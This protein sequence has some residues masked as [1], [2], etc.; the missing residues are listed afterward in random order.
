M[1]ECV[2]EFEYAGVS[3]ED[4]TPEWGIRN[5]E[6]VPMSGA[7]MIHMR[8]DYDDGK[9]AQC[10]QWLLMNILN[11]D[12]DD[13]WE[14]SIIPCASDGSS[15]CDTPF[16]LLYDNDKW[17]EVLVDAVRGTLHKY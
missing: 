14:I 2:Y 8:E 6:W 10:T 1:S 7:D 13:G 3:V 5:V 9:Y 12:S 16:I 4:S 17:D 11:G 15:P